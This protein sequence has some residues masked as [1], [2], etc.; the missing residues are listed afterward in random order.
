MK[1]KKIDNCKD[2]VWHTFA[3]IFFDYPN[4]I[5]FEK[6]IYL[7]NDDFEL[8]KTIEIL[9]GGAEDAIEWLYKKVPVLRNRCP[10]DCL[11]SAGG[12]EELKKV[13]TEWYDV[14]PPYKKI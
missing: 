2:E 14:P 13:L 8:A 6:L 7:V 11:N 3:A 10:I 5:G 1:K 12:I 4:T 9:L